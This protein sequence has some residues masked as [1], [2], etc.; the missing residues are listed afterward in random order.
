MCVCVCVC[1]CVSV[2]LCVCVS[3]CVCTLPYHTTPRTAPCLP[4]VNT[5]SFTYTAYYRVE[6]PIIHPVPFQLVVGETTPGVYTVR[7]VY[8]AGA[9]FSSLSDLVTRYQAG[10]VLKVTRTFPG[11]APGQG[12]VAGSLNLRGAAF[13]KTP[14]P[15]PRQY[16]PRGA[17]YSVVNQHVR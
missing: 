16:Q 13:P 1:V 5:T 12:S 8:Y 17:R 9:S 3:V 2:C 7:S 6:F 10:T 14:H 11:V 4:T 15:P